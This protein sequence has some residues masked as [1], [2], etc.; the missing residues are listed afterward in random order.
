[1]YD[2]FCM[3]FLD[4]PGAFYRVDQL[5]RTTRGLNTSDFIIT[6]VR[7]YHR[8]VCRQQQPRPDSEE[9][10]LTTLS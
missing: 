9:A 4:R 5:A 2:L 8:L 1:M 6:Q 10:Y 7:T 3:V